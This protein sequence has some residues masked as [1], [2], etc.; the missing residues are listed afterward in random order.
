M[1]MYLAINKN[2]AQTGQAWLCKLIR[3][4]KSGCLNEAEA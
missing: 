4:V 1:S 3:L 2:R